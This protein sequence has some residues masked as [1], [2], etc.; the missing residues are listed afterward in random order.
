[1]PLTNVLKKRLAKGESTQAG[2]SQLAA[3]G[4]LLSMV[5]CTSLAGPSGPGNCAEAQSNS[6]VVFCQDFDDS[7]LGDWN[8]NDL[9]SDFPGTSGYIAGPTGARNATPGPGRAT[10]VSGGNAVS[11]NSLRHWFPAN[12]TGAKSGTLFRAPIGANLE[13]AYFGYWVRFDPSIPNLKGGKLPGLTGGTSDGGQT[14][15]CGREMKKGFGFS[16]RLMFVEREFG[17]RKFSPYFYWMDNPR[18]PDSSG[19]IYGGPGKGGVYTWI[20]GEW[21][22]I[23]EHVK[24]NTPAGAANG[25]F[26]LWINGAKVTTI[27]NTRIRGPGATF[28]IGHILFHTYLGGPSGWASPTDTYNFFDVVVV[29]RNRIGGRGGG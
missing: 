22:F 12:T 25:L 16:S 10:I 17:E 23:E 13:E 26:E 20:P 9:K 19:K 7:A 2:I 11:G 27:A 1:M 4:L 14:P 29:S 15:C 24:L 6:G 3:L 18:P 5:A 8:V 21:Y 28:S